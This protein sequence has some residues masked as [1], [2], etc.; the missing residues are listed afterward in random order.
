MRSTSTQ[1]GDATEYL[2]DCGSIPA[3]PG[4]PPRPPA[5]IHLVRCARKETAGCIRT[6]KGVGRIK[7]G[8][9]ADERREEFRAVRRCNG[10]FVNYL[11]LLT[12]Q[13]RDVNELAGFLA[14]AVLDYQEFRC[15]DLQHRQSS[16]CSPDE[17][18]AMLTP[19]AQVNY[20]ALHR[21]R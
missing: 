10:A 4:C 17:E 6:F 21:R 12:L 9:H 1:N 13:H 14:A 15:D 3:I 7:F 20:G 5:T 2:M 8:L 18:S 16:S 19:D 11:Y